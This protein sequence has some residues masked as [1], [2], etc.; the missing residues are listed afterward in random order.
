MGQLR[1]SA[2]WGGLLMLGSCALGTAP[3]AAQPRPI[4]D[5]FQSPQQA[6]RWHTRRGH[7]A[8]R[9][10]VYEQT[11][12]DY[13]TVALRRGNL[14]DY[15]LTVRLQFVDVR[16]SYPTAGYAVV[17]L[18]AQDPGHYYALIVR[19]TGPLEVWEYNSTPSDQRGY[20]QRLVAGAGEPF[21]L[22]KWYLVQV[23]SRGTAFA[24]KAYAE[25]AQPPEGW[26]VE[27][28]FAQ[29]Q[30]TDHCGEQAY[31]GGQV[32]LGAS[33]AHVLFD[34]FVVNPQRT[35]AELLDRLAVLRDRGESVRPAVRDSPAAELL[36]AVL[37]DMD[38]LRGP[39]ERAGQLSAEDWAKQAQKLLA[40]EKRVKELRRRAILESGGLQKVSPYRE[41]T[42]L[43][44][45]RGNLNMRTMHSNG[46]KYADEAVALYKEAGYDF[47]CLADHDAYGDQD[48]GVLFPRYQ[49][50]RELHDWNGDGQTR[51][52]RIYRSGAEAYVRDYSRPAFSWVGRN[53]D[54]HQPGQ[55]V[56]FN[57]VAIAAERAEILCVGH[58]PGRIASPREQYGFLADL[59]EAGGLAILAHPAAWNYS[60]ALLH[61]NQHLR[62]IDG[63]EV[64]NGYYARDARV[65]G[66]EDGN[67][68]IATALWDGCLDAGL[69]L[70]GFANDNTH[71]YDPQ[72]PDPPFNGYN[73]VW[74]ASRTKQDILA[75]LKAGRFYASSGVE[76]DLVAV[77]GT[78]IRVVSP[79]ATRIR[80]IGERGTEL[81]LVEGRELTY[82]LS[83]LEHWLRVELEND[84]QPY[85]DKTFR[86]RAW[87]QP[88]VVADLLGS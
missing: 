4:A 18:R 69:R 31:Q 58:P 1:S 6:Q 47:V 44:K 17:V 82:E 22:E 55:F 20:W 21:D 64:Y 51:E 72:G 53:W 45:L 79:N 81:A 73:V 12:H 57:G 9:D 36:E 33:N 37:A 5:D 87:L 25:G 2:A 67:A 84:V 34:D 24:A 32:G 23:Q 85:P 3:V 49:T 38:Q 68:G 13:W 27:A 30:G 41:L 29:G 77:V 62:R 76:V 71:S 74:A 60:P 52:R 35:A 11:S 56:V 40:V 66:N 42:G 26:Q 8:C 50:D 28:D 86:Q 70:W 10:G 80:V 48:G 78:T 63:L 59:A 88:F 19:Q 61:E 14:Y 75:A 43:R 65:P 83:G 54:L 39:L 16:R 46:A 7:W 15:D